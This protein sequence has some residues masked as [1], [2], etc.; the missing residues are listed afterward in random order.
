MGVIFISLIYCNISKKKILV[1][2]SN[3]TEYSWTREVN[4]GLE[5]VLAHQDQ[6]QIFWYY[7]DTK[8]AK[9]RQSKQKSGDRAHMIISSLK[10][11]VI[12][13][14]DDDAQE[15]VA[16][17]Y[18][19]KPDISI[20]FAG[21]NNEL[22][23]YG[24][25]KAS[26][27]T[28]ILERIPVASL[29]DSIMLI[30]QEMKKEYPIKALHIGDNSLPDKYDDR[31]MHD[32]KDWQKI[33]LLPSLLVETFDEWKESILNANE[34]ADVIIL[35]NYRNIKYA[36]G[37]KKFVPPDEI[38]KWTNANSKIPVV[39]TYGFV[40]TDGGYLSIATSSIE[41][42]EVSAQ[43]AMD[44]IKK[45]SDSKNIPITKTKQFIVSLRP[46]N[47]NQFSITLP[48]VYT[49]FAQYAKRFYENIPNDNKP[50]TKSLTKES[51]TLSSS[52]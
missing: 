18:I 45:N 33:V 17:K 16:K 23:A 19:D 8:T 1:I 2:H 51:S 6:A 12:L 46:N 39:G 38:I 47:T 25:D 34:M 52:K 48:K 27:V 11:S 14:V 21:V 24:Y 44:I 7:M 42:G 9:N 30:G 40:V 20:V 3:S 31:F 22:K 37:D 28:G 35:T 4:E 36:K 43:M 29:R 13:A 41:Q 50:V 10:P 5:N 15:F 49:A 26:N 32:F